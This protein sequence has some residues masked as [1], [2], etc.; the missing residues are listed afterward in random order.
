MDPNKTLRMIDPKNRNYPAS[1]ECIGSTF[2]KNSAYV[3]ISEV[4]VLHK[5]CQ[6]NDLDGYIEIGT[7][8]IGYSNDDTA[9]E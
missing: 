4:N 5:S 2:E 8:K 3:A 1:I 9:L 6:H 7:T